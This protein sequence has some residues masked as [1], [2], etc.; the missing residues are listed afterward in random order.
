MMKVKL[1]KRNLLILIPVFALVCLTAVLVYHVSE[2]NGHGTDDEIYTCDSVDSSCSYSE[3]SVL[4]LDDSGILHLIDTATG[5]DMIYCDRPNCTHEGYSRSNENPSCPAA[6]WGLT[7]GGPVLHGGHMY[8]IGN[9]TDE[10]TLR[11]QYLYEMD[12]NGGSRR[13]AATLEGVETLRYVLY[14]DNYV[15]GAYYNRTEI[16]D[17]GQIV[18]DNKPEAGIF[19]IN[20]D[21]LEVY[22]GDRIA[23]EQANITGLYYEDGTVYYSAI[24]FDD[25][26]TELMID[27]ASENDYESFDYEN[28]QYELYRCDIANESTVKVGTMTHVKSLTL[29]DG[30]AYYETEDG[31]FV[32]DMDSG[33]TE[34]PGI[35]TGDGILYGGLEKA[36]DALYY[37]VSDDDGVTYYRLENGKSTELMRLSSDASFGIMN[38]CGQSVYV[39]YNDA[40]G[41]FCLGVLSLDELNGGSFEVRRLMNYNEE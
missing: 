26:V 34:E 1:K 22:M 4:Y 24:H 14:R 2:K 25:D 12:S 10:D 28:M 8:F 40:D 9:M 23:G 6:F 39:S 13:R 37:A 7:R 11:I 15:I 17:D 33:E 30:D 41:D 31:Y 16:N 29:V 3:N 20:L 32:L 21:S 35:S 27:D 18:D 36:G 38:I 5:K 19:V